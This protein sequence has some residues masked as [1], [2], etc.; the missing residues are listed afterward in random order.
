M[1]GEV[2]AQKRLKI[3]AYNVFSL[4]KGQTNRDMKQNR[5]KTTYIMFWFERKSRT[6]KSRTTQVGFDNDYD[7][8][9]CLKYIHSCAMKDIA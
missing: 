3:A 5:G 8:N 4:T 2:R 6:R 1:K 9:P 7:D